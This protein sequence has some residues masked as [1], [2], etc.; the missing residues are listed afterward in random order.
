MANP[1]RGQSLEYNDNRISLYSGQG[2]LCRITQIPLKIRQMETHHITPRHIG[3]TDE[4]KNLAFI[5]SYAHKM[6][7]STQ[8]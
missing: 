8:K 2:G 6:I 4:Y 7:H 3:G 1:I 5:H